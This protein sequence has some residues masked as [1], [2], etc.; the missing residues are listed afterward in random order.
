M[1]SEPEDTSYTCPYYHSK[2]RGDLCG[3]PDEQPLCLCE[4]DPQE[5]GNDVTKPDFAGAV[6]GDMSDGKPTVERGAK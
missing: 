3:Y 1:P 5:C 6:L 4:G 2:L